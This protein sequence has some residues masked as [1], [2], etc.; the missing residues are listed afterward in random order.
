MFYSVLTHR[1]HSRLASSHAWWYTGRYGGH[2][3]ETLNLMLPGPPVR[4]GHGRT[5]GGGS[6]AAGA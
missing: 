1:A 6:V 4:H 3:E 5:H 2:G